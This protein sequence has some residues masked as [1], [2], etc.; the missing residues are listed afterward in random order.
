MK[1]F[2]TK[3]KERFDYD[4]AS[5]GTYV[6]QEAEDIFE[7]LVFGSGLTSRINVMEEVKGSEKIKLLNVDFDLQS[8]DDCGLTDDGTITFNDRTITTERV[9]VQFSL[10]NENLNGTWAQMLNAIGAN[11]Q[12][13]EM[14]LE[15]VISAY[16]VKKARKKNQDLMFL[17]DTGSGD[18]NLAFYDGYVKLW[19]ADSSFQLAVRTGGPT[20]TTSN[21][22]ENFLSVYNKI[23]AELF[24]N[25]I[26]VEIISGRQEVRA[27][28]EQIWNDKDYS[29][30]L[31]KGDEGGEL[32]VRLP[33]TEMIIRSY[34]QLNGL[35]RIYA[36]PYQFM[37]FGTDLESDLDGFFIKYL[38]ESEKLR[39]GMKWR[40]GIQYVYPEYFVRLDY[41]TS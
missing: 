2:K 35:G 36:V 33:T 14:P 18:A 13:E 34:P 3:L 11:R 40:T 6:D 15:Q 31:E 21:A 20:I 37:F 27:L 22:F 29:A 24:D 38:D 9:G 25:E 41:T 10:C 23:P 16:V 5:I 26:P 12:D 1:S 28:V 32:W 4:V 39:F 19:D 17:G 7:D 8:A 30:E